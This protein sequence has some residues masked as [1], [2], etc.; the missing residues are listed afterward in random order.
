MG[1]QRELKKTIVYRKEEYSCGHR[2]KT[3]DMTAVMILVILFI[4]FN[5]GSL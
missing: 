3:F 1:L 2:E 5:V 4:V